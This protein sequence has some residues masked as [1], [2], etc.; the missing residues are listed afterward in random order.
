MAFEILAV[1]FADE[2][3][4]RFPDVFGCAFA[5]AEARVTFRAAGFDAFA[6]FALG[7]AAFGFIFRALTADLGGDLRAV[8]RDVDRLRPFVTELLT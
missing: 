5:A 6:R 1:F 2:V 3:E 7:R 4:E 8:A